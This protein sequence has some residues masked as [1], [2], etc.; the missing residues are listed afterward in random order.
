MR[1]GVRLKL[2]AVSR[3]LEF[4]RADPDP[5]PAALEAIGRLERL[6]ALARTLLGAQLQAQGNLGAAAALR[7]RVTP[8]LRLQLAHLVRLAAAVAAQEGDQALRANLRFGALTRIIPL[9][10]A[11]AALDTATRYRELLLRYGMPGEMLETLSRDLDRYAV[12]LAQRDDAS[13]TIAAANA[14]LERT[15]GE[16]HLIIR[17]LDA[18]NRIRFADHPD[19]L[20][21]WDAVRVVRWPSAS[22]VA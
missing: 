10:S 8:G 18:L 6:S 12:A 9:D 20:A 19:R 13:A 5:A 1:R 4:Y 11:K 14:D 17:H 2:D 16:A 7:E 15:A 22:R 3:V 21:E